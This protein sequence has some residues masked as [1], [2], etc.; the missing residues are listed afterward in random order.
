MTDPQTLERGII[1]TVAHPT[2]GEIP[3]VGTPLRFSR[4]APGVRRAAPRS[5]EHTDQILAKLGYDKKAIAGLRAKG[6]I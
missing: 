6:V 5:G 3:V 2:L 1:Q 4:M